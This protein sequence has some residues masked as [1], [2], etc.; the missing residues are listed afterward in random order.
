MK[1]LVGLVTVLTFFVIAPSVHAALYYEFAPDY[2]QSLLVASSETP[3]EVFLP[4]NEFLS[5]FD[6]WLSNADQAGQ[7]TITLLGPTGAQ[8]SAQTVELPA[9]ADTEDGT[10]YHVN[11]PGQIAVTGN[12]AYRI[13]ITSAMPTLRLYYASQIRLLPYNGVPPPIYTGGLARLGSTDQAYS[14]K[15]SLYENLEHSAPVISSVQTT[16]DQIDH[17]ILS[18]NANEPVDWHV[19]YAPAGQANGIIIDWTGSYASCLPTIRACSAVLSVIPDTLYNFTLSVRDN[20]GN[21]TTFN[22]TFTSLANGQTPPPSPGSS[23][24]AASPTPTPDTSAP[25]MTNTRIATLTTTTASFAWTTNEAANSIVVVQ[26]APILI[27]VGG[28]SDATLEL[29]H[30][31]TITNLSPDT[32]YQATITSRDAFNNAARAIITFLTPRQQ[33]PSSSPTPTPAS[34]PVGST[35]P[36]PSPVIQTT[37]PD[38]NPTISWPTPASGEPSDGYRI[39]VFDQNN[40][41]IKTI[42]VSANT[43]QIQLADIPLGQDRVVIYTNNDGT[44]QKVAAPAEVNI[45]KRPLLERLVSSAP[46]ILGSI[47]L[48]I[49]GAIVVLKIK[50][51][52]KFAPVVFTPPAT[53]PPAPPVVG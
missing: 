7:A 6:L 48:V 17:A 2:A 49:A 26:L 37:G 45:K 51:R 12:A 4:Q 42:T 14:F 28:S 27:S 3:S 24:S 31:I 10:R 21:T 53:P 44:Y 8:L 40:Q 23:P 34:T 43:H 38:D 5:G 19:S 18:F 50:A 30:F 35:S 15:F 25:V 1:W 36:T 22:G 52:K 20:W 39:D 32:Y 46:Y 13:Q 11:L 29:E 33:A 47:V 9:I 41:L 16:Q